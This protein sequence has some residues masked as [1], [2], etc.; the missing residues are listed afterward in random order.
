L[1]IEITDRREREEWLG[2]AEAVNADDMV[3]GNPAQA[4]ENL[5]YSVN[6]SGVKET[7]NDTA[8]M[9]IIAHEFA[10]VVLRHQSIKVVVI[11]VRG[12][13]CYPDDAL[14]TLSEWFE[15]TANLQVWLWG[16]RKEMT[17]FFEAYPKARRPRWYV[18]LEIEEGEGE[19]DE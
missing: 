17:A 16:F 19:Q 2:S 1:V 12:L 18:E 7:T 5:D 13:G 11:T 15:D 10:H 14:D 3:S 8:A 9:F 4:A 6:L